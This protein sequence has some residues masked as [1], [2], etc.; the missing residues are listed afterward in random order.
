MV[1]QKVSVSKEQNPNYSDIADNEFHCAE[2]HSELFC[3]TGKDSE[4]INYKTVM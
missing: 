3:G 1:S 4:C 2:L